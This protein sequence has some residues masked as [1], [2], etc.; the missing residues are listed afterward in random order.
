MIIPTLLISSA[1]TV[2]APFTA[3]IDSSLRISSTL[4]AIKK[5]LEYSRDMKIVI[6]DGTGFD[7]SSLLQ[8]YFPGANS[9][10]LYFHNDT[11][12]VSTKGKGYGEGEIIEYALQ[13]STLLSTSDFFAKCTSKLWVANYHQCLQLW[14]G[15]ILVNARFLMAPTLDNVALESIDTRF[16]LINKNLYL[17]KFLHAHESV[18]DYEHHYLEHCFKDVI[19]AHGIA[20]CVFPI[21][22]IIHGISGTT[23]EDYQVTN[24]LNQRID[25]AI[26]RAI[27][28]ETTN[29]I[30]Q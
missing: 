10:C 12:Q 7:F 21:S 13:H 26:K 5:W 18:T 25:E 23:G 20:S 24:S 16:Y 6:C 8:E 15:H 22:P 14:N 4:H 29:L 30:C 19:T 11:N 2:T 3:L 17:S 1:V 9:E 27:A 28:I